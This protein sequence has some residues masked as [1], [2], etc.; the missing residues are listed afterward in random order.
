MVTAAML[1]INTGSDQLTISK[2]T[3]Q[4]WADI[5][6]HGR[7]V[8]LRRHGDG[9]CIEVEQKPYDNLRLLDVRTHPTRLRPRLREQI[10]QRV[11]DATELA[12]QLRTGPRQVF[13]IDIKQVFRTLLQVLEDG[14]HGLKV[15]RQVVEVVHGV[16]G[17]QLG[18]A[19]IGH[20]LKGI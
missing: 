3:M 1:R 6:D 12:R 8:L 5:R 15:L 18:C 10:R 2:S 9:R 13:P 14:A 7:A 19:E 11:L 20:L 4:T 16:G 17:K